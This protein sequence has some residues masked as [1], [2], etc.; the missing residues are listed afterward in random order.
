MGRW[1]SLTGTLLDGFHTP[2]MLVTLA[3]LA[4]LVKVAK[5]F[6]M[7]TSTY[8]ASWRTFVTSPRIDYG[9]KMGRTL[10]AIWVFLPIPPKR[11]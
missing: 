5:H 6:K 4:C 11:V 2:D 1:I 7:E 3:I 8:S 10:V 9:F